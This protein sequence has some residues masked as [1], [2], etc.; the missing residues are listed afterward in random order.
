ML[1]AGFVWTSIVLAALAAGFWWK[2]ST[3]EIHRGD[4]RSKGGFF[5]NTLDVV[6]TAFE[7]SRW[8]KWAAIATAASIIAQTIAQL[9]AG[10]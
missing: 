10:S 5:K 9:I 2:A 6:S 1:H 7:Q 4:P 3:I 8:N